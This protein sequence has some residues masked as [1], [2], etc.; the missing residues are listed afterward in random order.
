ME[1]FRTNWNDTKRMLGRCTDDIDLLNERRTTGLTRLANRYRRF[2]ILSL[3]C[4]LSMPIS[5]YRLSLESAV[6]PA[7]LLPL[8]FATFMLLC[9]SLDFWLF[10]RISRLDVLTMSVAE[11][12][13]RSTLLRKRHLQIAGILLPMAFGVLGLTAYMLRANEW[14]VYG[15]AT[16]AAVGLVIGLSFLAAFM[17]DYKAV[18]G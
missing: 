10:T 16:G 2:A 8:V 5:W 1:S 13:R 14:H 12:V 15:M 17:R 11:I 3:I 6:E 7:W 18:R 4:A 9:S